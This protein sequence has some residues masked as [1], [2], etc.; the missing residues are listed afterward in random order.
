MTQLGG[1][2]THCMQIRYGI[3]LS[4]DVYLTATEVVY[5]YIL[6][7]QCN[8]IL[9]GRMKDVISLCYAIHVIEDY[10]ED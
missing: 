4:S 3:R 7:N 2:A 6:C 9:S 10:D 8:L 5:M 1:I